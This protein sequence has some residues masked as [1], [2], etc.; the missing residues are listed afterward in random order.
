VL[1]GAIQPDN[2]T[3]AA[4]NNQSSGISTPNRC[5]G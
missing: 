4:S 2:F 5:S 3:C 1:N